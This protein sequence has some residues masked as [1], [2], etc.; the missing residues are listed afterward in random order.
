MYILEIPGDEKRRSLLLH[1]INAI[2]QTEFSD[3][4]QTAIISGFSYLESSQ[5][6]KT[7]KIAVKDIKEFKRSLAQAHD[8]QKMAIINNAHNLTTEAQNALLKDLEDEAVN[9]IIILALPDIRLVLPTIRSRGVHIKEHEIN[10]IHPSLGREKKAK[11]VYNVGNSTTY[12][13]QFL[14]MSLYDQL[15]YI[16]KELEKP[17]NQKKEVAVAVDKEDAVESFLRDLLS[18]YE[19]SLDFKK[20]MMVEIGLERIHKGVKASTVLEHL[21]LHLHNG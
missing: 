16:T 17:R 7:N 14:H 12:I 1:I 11:I 8:E 20:A 15:H 6:T 18:Y 13:E 10:L 3:I 2:Y 4:A 9:S 5:S 19:L 21:T